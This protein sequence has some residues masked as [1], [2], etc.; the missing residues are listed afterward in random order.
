MAYRKPILIQTADDDEWRDFKTCR[1]EI[2]GVGGSSH[3]G[4]GAPQSLTA[5]NFRVPY[6]KDL[7]AL[8]PGAC[9]I[10]FAG[11]TYTV[12]AI[13]DFEE[14]QITLTFKTEAFYG[15]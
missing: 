3:F 7:A 15:R 13:D 12:L 2:H 11:K 4:A 10:L 9:R 5:K 14:R 1:A 8:H 6:H